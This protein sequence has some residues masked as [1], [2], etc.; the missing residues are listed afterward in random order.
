MNYVSDKRAKAFLA[1][2]CNISTGIPPTKAIS[3]QLLTKPGAKPEQIHSYTRKSDGMAY[4]GKE[5][6]R[7]LIPCYLYQS[8]NQIFAF[9]QSALYEESTIM[10]SNPRIFRSNDTI[11]EFGN[12]NLAFWIINEIF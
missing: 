7:Q 5:G 9:R 11:E 12:T 6:M 3:N 8:Y 4:I 2:N 10:R 1:N